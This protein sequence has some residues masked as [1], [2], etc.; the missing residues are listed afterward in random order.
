MSHTAALITLQGSAAVVAVASIS[1]P[2]VVPGEVAFWIS[3]AGMVI[4]LADKVVDIF[5]K[6]TRKSAKSGE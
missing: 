2:S 6:A 3:I 1:D 5:K 4:T